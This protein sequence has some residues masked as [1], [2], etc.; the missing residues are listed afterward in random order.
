MVHRRPTAPLD[1]RTDEL[2]QTSLECR[3]LGHAWRFVPQGKARRAE[4]LKTGQTEYVRECMRCTAT[5]TDLIDLDTG[6]IERT[7]MHYP[8]GYLLTTHGQGH[9]PRRFVRYELL[10]RMHLV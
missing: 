1:D 5:A 3:T 6:G 8:E 9:L 7:K 2:S 4:L 10:R